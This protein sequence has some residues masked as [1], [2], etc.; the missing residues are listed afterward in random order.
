MWAIRQDEP[1]LMERDFD[2]VG[3]GLQRYG[4]VRGKT[5]DEKKSQSGQGG[6]RSRLHA[7]PGW[8]L[9]GKFRRIVNV[10]RPKTRS[11]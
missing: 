7:G 1:R 8:V 6:P 9:A 3:T 5:T 10:I 4:P 11:K 2:F